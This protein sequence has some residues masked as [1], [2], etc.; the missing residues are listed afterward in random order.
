MVDQ[1]SLSLCLGGPA[2][3]I[4]AGDVVYAGSFAPNRL[5]PDMAMEP[6]KAA[7]PG[8]S[9]A[10]AKLKPAE[11]INGAQGQCEGT[12]LYA[13][14]LPNRPFMDSYQLGSRAQPAPP[15]APTPP[16]PTPASST[17]PAAS[18]APAP[19]ANPTSSGG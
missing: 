15:S 17:P 7:F 8:L 11:W 16:T 19:A 5:A 10:V 18:A 2:F 4:A 6:A 14:E 13:M 1:V 3:D 12:Y 9:T